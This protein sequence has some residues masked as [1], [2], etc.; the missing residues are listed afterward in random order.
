MSHVTIPANV[1]V[2]IEAYIF[3]PPIA[4]EFPCELCTVSTELMTLTDNP[5]I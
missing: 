2:I 3:I 4:L 1:A 5:C